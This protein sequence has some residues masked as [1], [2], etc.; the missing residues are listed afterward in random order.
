M[1][2][3]SARKRACA[4]RYGSTHSSTGSVT[5]A[6]R[7]V[8]AGVGA[9]LAGSVAGL[10]S[11]VSYPALLATGLAPV[12]ANVTSTVAHGDRP[13]RAGA[14]GRAGRRRLPVT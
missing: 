12:T 10:A 1:A 2:G 4:S 13:R 7:T 6:G 14:R 5:S 8:A 3:Y 9:G 11:L